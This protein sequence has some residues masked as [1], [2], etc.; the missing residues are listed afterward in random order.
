MN[1]SHGIKNHRNE[2]SNLAT[3]KGYQMTVFIQVTL[4]E[5][6][7][8]FM[9][10][11]PTLLGRCSGYKFYEHPILGDESPIYVISPKGKIA[12]SDFWEV[13]DLVAYTKQKL[14]LGV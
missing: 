6:A 9:S 1:S 10:H 12:K 3:L 13:D 4:S 5:N 8:K 7:Q 2:A 14:G 11:N